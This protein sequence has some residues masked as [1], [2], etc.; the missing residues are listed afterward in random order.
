MKAEWEDQIGKL[1]I[2]QSETEDITL[3]ALSKKQMFER[4]KF[5]KVVIGVGV[6]VG[7]IIFVMI[8]IFT[9]RH[10]GS[11]LISTSSKIVYWCT[12]RFQP[13]D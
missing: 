10:R 1:T 5:K 6:V 11:G 3:Y 4:R 7:L 8:Y 12:H 9:I 13:I 2:G